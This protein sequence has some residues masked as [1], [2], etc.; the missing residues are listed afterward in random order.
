MSTFA[1]VHATATRVAV[2][3]TATRP[4][5]TVATAG[6]ARLLREEDLA[7][8][9]GGR[10]GVRVDVQRDR[11]RLEHGEVRLVPEHRDVAGRRRAGALDREAVRLGGR[12]ATEVERAIADRAAGAAAVADDDHARAERRD[13][14]PH[15]RKRDRRRG[16]RVGDAEVVRG[17]RRGRHDEREARALF[18]GRHR[19]RRRSPASAPASTGATGTFG[20]AE[21]TASTLS[22][23]AT[24]AP[25][26]PVVP[27]YEPLGEATP[28]PGCTVAILLAPSSVKT[29]TLPPDRVAATCPPESASFCAVGES[30]ERKFGIDRD[31]RLRREAEHLEPGPAAARRAREDDLPVA[32]V[33]HEPD[34]VGL[35]GV[36]TAT[37]E[38]RA[39]RDRARL[40]PGSTGSTVTRALAPFGSISR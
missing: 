26:T 17:R 34:A 39:R 13:R 15:A 28:V 20:P 11:A 3:A 9:R 32:A 36:R 4:S 27:P 30:E 2:A 12:R 29:T 35:V 8:R 37:L 40:P 1:V 22:L 14:A 38:E 25:V 6:D 21:R 5:R 10:R 24:H 23:A 16:L 31:L 33:G 19:R 7:Q 18:A